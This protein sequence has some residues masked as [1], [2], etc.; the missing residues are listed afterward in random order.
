MRST[1]SENSVNNQ[2]E[3]EVR[4]TRIESPSSTPLLHKSPLQLHAH[5]TACSSISSPAVTVVQG[6]VVRRAVITGATPISPVQHM[7]PSFAFPSAALHKPVLSPSTVHQHMSAAS[8]GEAQSVIIS[9]TGDSSHQRVAQYVNPQHR[10]IDPELHTRVQG[11]TVSMPSL[12]LSRHSV[13]GVT[14]QLLQAKPGSPNTYRVLH[15]IG[16]SKSMVVI[17]EPPPQSVQ[18]VYAEPI[19][20]ATVQPQP[21]VSVDPFRFLHT[22]VPQ[23]KVL[24]VTPQ[25]QQ[26][27][28]R[29]QQQPPQDT[30]TLG[31]QHKRPVPT[32][33]FEPQYTKRARF[34][35]VVTQGG[36]PQ[37]P[38]PRG[39]A[40]PSSGTTLT[41]MG[42]SHSSLMQQLPHGLPTRTPVQPAPIPLAAQGQM[43]RMHPTLAP[44]Q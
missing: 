5:S 12:G 16:S 8:S 30:V 34:Y 31:V 10:I 11:Q 24:P 44:H 4:I 3:D 26:H 32:V 39:P 37:P 1:A 17:P 14:S 41:P 2:D 38:F 15:N 35:T 6:P 42:G 40:V 7:V 29:K 20:H 28:H 13:P 33:L 21:N 27:H 18:K 19:S 36:S 9:R 43:S 25:Q 22:V 23:P